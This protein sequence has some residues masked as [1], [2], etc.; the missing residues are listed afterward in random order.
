MAKSAFI[1]LNTSRSTINDSYEGFYVG[2]TDNMFN[3]PSKDYSF[4]AI[5]SI[6]VVTDR[7]ND[8]D[9]EENNQ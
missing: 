9:S 8:N 5:K 4:N 6:K 7:T 2:I 1:V 3:T